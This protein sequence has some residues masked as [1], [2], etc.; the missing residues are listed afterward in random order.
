M[1]TKNKMASKISA[2]STNKTVVIKTKFNGNDVLVRT[3]TIKNDSL[4][5]SLLHA[6]SLEYIHLNE[7]GRTKLIEKLKE[8][9][10]EKIY[11]K[12]WN[13]NSS[14]MVIKI[15]VQKYMISLITDIYKY[16]KTETVDRNSLC[17]KIIEKIEE[18]AEVYDVIFNLISK[19]DLKEIVKDTFSD[20]TDEKLSVCKEVIIMRYRTLFSTN[21]N[22]LGGKIS[23][24]KLK[25]CERRLLNFIEMILETSEEK[26]F[27]DYVK[28]VL[29]EEMVVDRNS[30]KVLSEYLNRNIYFVDVKTRLPFFG[31][32]S[33][34]CKK[35]IIILFID[36]KY[37]IMG[38]LLK[39]NRIKR[40]FNTTDPLI[41]RLKNK[42]KS[43]R[44]QAS[45]DDP[46]PNRKYIMMSSDDDDDD[47]NDVS[48]EDSSDDDGNKYYEKKKY[49]KYY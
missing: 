22:K 25:Y 39:Q 26:A 14:T 31:Y 49:S 5:H 12:R 3:G 1:Y 15:P 34:N 19:H 36:N 37:E 48:S 10:S 32:D 33:K 18:D 7:E 44:K 9:L 41:K 11:R 38:R 21:I 35:S 45:P 16:K 8:N 42:Y 17:R 4:I 13:M 29:K 46:S 30:I 40:E 47:D 6:N 28:N 20:N 27:R 23:R 43:K 24:K 2:L